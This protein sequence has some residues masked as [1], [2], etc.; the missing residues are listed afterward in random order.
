MGFFLI[1]KYW[2]FSYSST[3]TYVVG[4]HQKRLAEALLM[5]TH[6]ICFRGEISEKY[7]PDT[8]SY[9]DLCAAKE[10]PPHVFVKKWEKIFFFFFFQTLEL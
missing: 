7:T 2:Y 9:L 1:Q 5:S 8:H 3:K 6:N 4:T 10:Y